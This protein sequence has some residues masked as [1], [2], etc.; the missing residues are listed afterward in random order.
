[1]SVNPTFLKF[2]ALPTRLVM[3]KVRVLIPPDGVLKAFVSAGATTCPLKGVD[4]KF[5]L[6]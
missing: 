2:R 6:E 3:V 1:V 5:P 4:T